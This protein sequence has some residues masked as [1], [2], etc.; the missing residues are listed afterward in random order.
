[1]YSLDFNL[2]LFLQTPPR[3]HQ[4]Q[5]WPYNATYVDYIFSSADEM[6]NGADRVGD[7]VRHLVVCQYST[8]VNTVSFQSIF[9]K[10][11]DNSKAHELEQNLRGKIC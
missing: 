7:S 3:H 4:V 5:Y 2:K 10:P 6:V 9:T 1:M 11:G 8:S